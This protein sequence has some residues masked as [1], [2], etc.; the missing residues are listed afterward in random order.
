[1]VD[2][3]DDPRVVEPQGRGVDVLAVGV[4]ADGQQLGGLGVVDV[5]GE[6]VPAHDPVERRGDEPVHGDLGRGDLALEL[7]LRAAPPRVHEGSHEVLQVRA[8]R[9]HREELGV[10]RVQQL[11]GVG[12]GAVAPALV[13][14]QEPDD[15]LQQEDGALH[16]EVPLLLRPG[17]VEPDHGDVGRLLRVADVG[18]ERRVQGVAPVGAPGVVEV[19]DVEPRALRVAPG[20]EPEV[21]E[22][23][24]GEVRE[25]E[26]VEVLDVA[27]LDGLLDEGHDDREGLPRA[28]GAQHHGGPEGVDQVD[29]PPADAPPVVEAGGEVH[30]FRGGHQAGLL[31]E[32][33]VLDVEVIAAQPPGEHAPDPDGARR[34]QPESQREG[35][36]VDRPRRGRRH[37]QLENPAVEPDED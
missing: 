5:Q 11:D 34:A 33:L 32:G 35:R 6:V 31:P 14:P 8:G 21:V 26:V 30:R 23:R 12:E 24:P 17:A 37:G 7:V 19:D 13:D 10:G 3:L 18:Q 4:V 28:R 9:Q 16:E 20:V 27:L 2:E 29:P 1:M 36:R 15:R 25:L 22:H